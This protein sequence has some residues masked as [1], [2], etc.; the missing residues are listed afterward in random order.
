MKNNLP[1]WVDRNKRGVV[2]CV[3]VADFF[4]EKLTPQAKYMLDFL[5]CDENIDYFRGH[6][7]RDHEIYRNSE[8]LE[9]DWDRMDGNRCY[10]LSRVYELYDNLQVE[11]TGEPLDYFL[12]C[13]EA[14]FRMLQQQL[15]I[16]GDT[17]GPLETSFP[18]E[19]RKKS[20]KKKK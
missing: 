20:Q 3:R 9:P 4:L 7:I 18:K 6:D 14:Y 2:G 12:L 11:N 5:I 10:D 19:K 13:E 17:Y 8:T 1:E 15:G 16:R